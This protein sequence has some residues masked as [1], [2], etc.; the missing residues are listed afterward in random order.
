MKKKLTYLNNFG[1][2]IFTL[3]YSWIW[4]YRLNFLTG[5]QP[6]IIDYLIICGV[7]LLIPLITYKLINFKEYKA[8]NIG[9]IVFLAIF[10]VIII[11]KEL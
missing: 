8:D 3:G 7:F 11:Y 10:I 4:L 5:E 9:L 2:I 1:L 6:E